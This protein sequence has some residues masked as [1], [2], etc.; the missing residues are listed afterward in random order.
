MDLAGIGHVLFLKKAIEVVEMQSVN[1]LR[2][3]A[4]SEIFI[5]P[6][7]ILMLFRFVSQ[8]LSIY[9]DW[10]KWSSYGDVSGHQGGLL[11]EQVKVSL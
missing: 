10:Q 3:I 9:C 2:T 4:F 6:L 5:F 1:I 11:G 7:S 8:L